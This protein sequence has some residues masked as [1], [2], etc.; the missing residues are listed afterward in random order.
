MHQPTTTTAEPTQVLTLRITLGPYYDNIA[1]QLEAQ[2]Q[3]VGALEVLIAAQLVRASWRMERC[4]TALDPANQDIDRIRQRA[5]ISML[6][7]LAELRQL[8]ADRCLKAELNL[9]LPGITRV[10]DVVNL[11][12]RTRT[13]APKPETAPNAAEVESQIAALMSH[14]QK[15]Q[16]S[17]LKIRTHPGLTFA[18]FALC[19]CGSGE[20]REHCC[21]KDA[22]P[23]PLDWHQL[24]QDAA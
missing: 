14:E 2:L 7:N 16:S 8:Q 23:V 24:L 22:L 12:K 10:R 15:L 20:K 17:D 11:K 13:E 1:E 21:R 5:E 19:P 3:P 6:R 18:E 4:E 9:H